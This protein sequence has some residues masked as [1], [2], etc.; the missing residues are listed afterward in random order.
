MGAH[1]ILRVVLIIKRVVLYKSLGILLLNRSNQNKENYLK[2]KKIILFNMVKITDRKVKIWLNVFLKKLFLKY[3][4]EKFFF[5]AAEQEKTIG[6][7]S[8]SSKRGN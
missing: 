4:P 5:L 7:C 2:R 3:S 1:L 8:T 6:Y